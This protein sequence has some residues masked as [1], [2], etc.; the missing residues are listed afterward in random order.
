MELSVTWDR[1][2]QIWWA[3][4]WR[5]ILIMIPAMLVGG[6]AGG[7]VGVLLGLAGARPETI[8]LAT[9]PVGFLV[10]AASSIIPLK[11]ILGKDFGE[12]RLVLL[13]KSQ[14]VRASGGG[15]EAS[16]SISA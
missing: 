5:N 11:M 8:R 14:A 4:F 9:F 12:F 10:G 1:T 15:S 7:V 2:A 13:S 6:L 16:S 3:F